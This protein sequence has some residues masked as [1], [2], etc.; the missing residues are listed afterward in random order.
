MKDE[1]SIF[2]LYHRVHKELIENIK[3]MAE[4]YDFNRGELP[5]LARLIKGGDNVS[6]KEIRESLPISKS[7]I[8]KTINNLVKKGYLRKEEDPKD[9]RATL[10]CLTEKGEKVGEVIRDID[11]KAEKTMVE[12][13]SESEKEELTSYLERLLM[14]LQKE[15]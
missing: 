12:G 15:K 5:I 9:K 2:N 7:T 11:K 6:Q 13:F 8:S 10:I 14:N 3:K 4:P 1:V